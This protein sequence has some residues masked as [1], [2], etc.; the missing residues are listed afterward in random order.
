VGLKKHNT[1]FLFLAVFELHCVACK[2]RVS[3][4]RPA[5]KIR[6]TKAF[7]LT[8]QIFCQQWKNNILTKHLLIWK[9]VTYF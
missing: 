6:P 2:S 5:G 1:Y 8:A 7:H 9:N 3:H 4:V